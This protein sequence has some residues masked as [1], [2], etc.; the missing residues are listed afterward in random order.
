[1]KILINFF[2]HIYLT[3]SIEA[4]KR[5]TSLFVL[6]STIESKGEGEQSGEQ[7][8]FLIIM[9][10]IITYENQRD[11]IEWNA[12]GLWFKIGWHERWVAGLIDATRVLKVL[13][14]MLY[15]KLISLTS[16]KTDG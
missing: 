16:F 3:T 4:R 15:L 1:M 7:N 5:N 12:F 2:Y 11:V 14:S 6:L 13:A 8:I 10:A 9:C